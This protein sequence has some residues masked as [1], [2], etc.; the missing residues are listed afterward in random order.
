MNV[1]VTAISVSQMAELV[2]L[3]RARFY[4]LLGTAFPPPLHDVRTRRPFYSAELQQVCLEVKQTNRGVDGCSMLFYRKR[5]STT[6]SKAPQ[7]V[8][9]VK[10]VDLIDALAS[11]GLS[12]SASQVETAVQ[13]VFPDGVEQIDGEVIRSIFIHIKKGTACPSSN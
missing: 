8:T 3:S 13:A 6:K 10:Y 1:E 5:K 7:S 11:L 4:Q 9:G 2:G 12:V